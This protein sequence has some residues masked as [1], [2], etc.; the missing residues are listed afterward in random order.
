MFLNQCQEENEQNSAL[1]KDKTQHVVFTTYN[2]ELKTL[3]LFFEGFFRVV[4]FSVSLGYFKNKF[5]I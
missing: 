3:E 4:Y 5:D 2:L 1:F